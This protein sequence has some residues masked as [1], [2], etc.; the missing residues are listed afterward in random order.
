MP[1]ITVES[2]N[3]QYGIIYGRIDDYNWYAL[4]QKEKVSYGINPVTLEKGDGKVSRLFVYKKFSSK[5][6]NDFIKSV[7]ADYRHKWN[8]LEKDKKEL[9]TRLV[10][11]LELRYSLKV[12]KSKAK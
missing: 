2:K 1:K 8:W 12:L 4:V 10:N 3:N 5:I 7:V 9:I 6:P 11:Y